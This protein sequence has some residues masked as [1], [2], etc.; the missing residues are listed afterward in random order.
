MTP[1]LT[2]L[3]R[4]SVRPPSFSTARAP[5]LHPRLW[6]LLHRAWD[7]IS[8]LPSA[9]YLRWNKL[10]WGVEE[11]VAQCH[12]FLLASAVAEAL[13]SDLTVCH[14]CFPLTSVL[15]SL[16]SIYFFSTGVAMTWW[17]GAPTVAVWWRSVGSSSH[18]GLVVVVVEA[19]GEL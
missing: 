4:I 18:D 11:G 9:P 10:G 6:S 8:R 12:L 14:L 16:S 17:W 15:A 3:R 2:S 7:D 13:D 19:D 5:S 1:V